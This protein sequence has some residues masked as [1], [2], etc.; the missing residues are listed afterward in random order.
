MK[1]IPLIRFD[2]FA[3]YA[4][5]PL[6][7]FLCDELSW[8]EHGNE[9]VLGL[10]VKDR[11]D[12]DFGGHI[13]GK[14]RKGRYRWVSG[15]GFCERKRH[16]EVELR[17]EME[18]MAALPDEDYFQGDEQGQPVDFFAAHA[19][20]N[21]VHPAFKA[22]RDIEAYSAARGIIEPMMRWY[23]DADGNFIEQF[24]TTGFDSRIWELYLFAAFTEMDYEISRIH[25]VPDF[26]CGNPVGEFTVEAV[27]VNASRDAKGAIVAPPPTDTPEER[28]VFIREYMPTR[29]AG[30]LKAKL[31]KR[32]WEKPHVGDK[33]LLFAIQDFSAPGSMTFTRS[34]FERYVYGYEPDWERDK[35]GKLIIKPRKIGLHRWG[36]K[37]VPSGFFDLPDAEHVSAILFSNSG[38]ISKFSRMG[39]LAGFGSERLKLVLVGTAVNHDPNA[40]APVTF[41]KQVRDAGYVETWIEGIDIWH[42][43]NALH[44]LDPNLMPDVAH[45]WLLPDGN[46]RS[47]T[48][49]WHPMGSITLH[50]LDGEAVNT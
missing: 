9:R 39:L 18:R 30:T 24:Q 46:V 22:L 1:P 41:K 40:S 47:V 49:K 6:I 21:K 26:C 31:E 23:E 15:T 3:A 16:A 48:P 38:T 28:D 20:E 11:T 45:H 5:Q 4:R 7:R 44:P 35:D 13:F 27:T 33:P 17:R 25:A 12:H 36:A 32:Y 37:Q 50:S 19:E 8:F 43:P 10:T 29:F 42:N 34:A 2:A 14:D